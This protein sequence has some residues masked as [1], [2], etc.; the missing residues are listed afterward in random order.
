MALINLVAS[1]PLRYSKVSDIHLRSIWIY[2]HRKYSFGFLRVYNLLVDFIFGCVE[3][4]GY[5]VFLSFNFR[6]VGTRWA[7]G[8]LPTKYFK[9][10][11][12]V[13]TNFI[14]IIWT[15]LNECPPNI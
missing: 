15:L 10:L 3:L 6:A 8:H 12:L 9:L 14:V 11:V 4:I 1:D 2:Y 5:S 13:P 7:Q